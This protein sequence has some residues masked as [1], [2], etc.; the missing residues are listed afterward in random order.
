MN[1]STPKHIPTGTTPS[2][3]LR[4]DLARAAAILSVVAIHAAENH[5]VSTALSERL[6]IFLMDSSRFSVPTFLFLAGYL[7]R[8]HNLTL[9][10][11]A[12]RFLRVALP[13]LYVSLAV[14]PFQWN[15]YT[16]PSLFI[17]WGCVLR[18]LLLCNVVGIYYF[19]FIVLYLYLLAYIFHRYGGS[20]RLLLW[21][22]PLLYATNILDQQW[23][24]TMLEHLNLTDWFFFYRY[25]TPLVYS[26]YF[27]SGMAFKLHRGMGIITRQR[28]TVL[29]C[30]ILYILLR[31]LL[32]DKMGITPY[33]PLFY[34][35]ILFFFLSLNVDG[36]GQ[37]G[38]WVR[39]LST[40]S[41]TIFLV[42]ILLLYMA[43]NILLMI[44]HIETYPLL[45]NASLYVFAL[46]SS[47]AVRVIAIGFLKMRATKV[48]I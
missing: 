29:S 23:S 46:F 41:Y 8:R 27:I 24:K 9:N 48:L 33:E 3:D 1:P 34:F 7:F 38:R 32:P 40:A 5:I 20:A 13:Y 14:I 21:L 17:S 42:H 31:L 35:A 30:S 4:L 44:W 10:Y 37:I 2:R 43:R 15:K 19:V 36:H 39:F 25:R 16:Y 26:L 11:L 47:I 22:L 18:D 45:V 12:H 28:R 6:V